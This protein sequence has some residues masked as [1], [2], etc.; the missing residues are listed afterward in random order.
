MNK[1]QYQWPQ[2][3]D[4]EGAG[5]KVVTFKEDMDL[6]MK[7]MLAAHQ[8]FPKP[9]RAPF[10]FNFKLMEYRLSAQITALDTLFWALSNR[11]IDSESADIGSMTIRL[12]LAAQNQCRTTYLALV[13]RYGR[14]SAE[15]ARRAETMPESEIDSEPQP[16]VADE[17]PAAPME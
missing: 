7:K 4:L 9:I 3:A 14:A 2:D 12:A 6:A 11:G 10:H 5:D 8:S 1:M 13:E 15:I 16:E 17:Q